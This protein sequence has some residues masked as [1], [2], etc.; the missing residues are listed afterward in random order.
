MFSSGITGD[1]VAINPTGNTIVAPSNGVISAV[2]PSKHAVGMTLSNGAEILVH[3]GLNTVMLE[4]KGFDVKV[5]EGQKVNAGEVLLTF[6]RTLIEKAGYSLITPI[7]VANT[8]EFA[9]LEKTD[10]KKINVGERLYT[11][12]A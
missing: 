2:L 5:T 4:G 1:G 11:I 3:V 12:K 7:L 10:A 6:D 8:D 9:S